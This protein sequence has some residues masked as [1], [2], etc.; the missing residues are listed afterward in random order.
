[1]QSKRTRRRDNGGK[2]DRENQ[3]GKGWATCKKLVPVKG[4]E[5]ADGEGSEQ[6]A[7]N[8]FAVNESFLG[9]YFR[10]FPFLLAYGRYFT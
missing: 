7:D 9:K 5:D 3:R 6:S 1:M 8:T 4:V 2:K 10:V